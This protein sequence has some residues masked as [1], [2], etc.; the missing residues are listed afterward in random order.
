[1]EEH[2]P[3]GAEL[4][5]GYIYARGSSDDKGPMYAVLFAAKAILDCGLPLKR[6]VRVIFF[7]C[8]EES[9]FGCVNHYFNVAK[10]ERPRYAFTPD[11]SFP[12]IYAE[13]GIAE[14]DA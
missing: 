10:E 7:G 12:L 8:N 9:G 13:K 6:R 2:E 5:D 1:M 3:Y 4:V 11:A 14:P